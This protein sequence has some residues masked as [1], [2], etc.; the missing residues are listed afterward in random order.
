MKN[1]ILYFLITV[2]F[3]SKTQGKEPTSECFS[4]VFNDTKIPF[5]IHKDTLQSK[6]LYKGRFIRETEN[7]EEGLICLGYDSNE[8]IY[9]TIRPNICQLSLF[10]DDRNYRLKKTYFS[11]LFDLEAKK[12]L[13]NRK[14]MS[15]I[16]KNIHDYRL[17]FPILNL[18]K[19]D[20]IQVGKKVT[21]QDDCNQYKISFS[22]IDI[23]S[24]ALGIDI[25]EL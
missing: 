7:D 17:Y 19:D 10:F 21:I 20:L 1:V 11:L 6:I 25:S 15:I 24:F 14:K 5:G 9:N 23:N 18:V 8:K 22:K 12:L 4:I 16:K 3:F 13:C 2:A